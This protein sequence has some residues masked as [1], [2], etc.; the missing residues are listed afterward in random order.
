MDILHVIE[1]SFVF[2]KPTLPFQRIEMTSKVNFFI[3]L[4]VYLKKE[5]ENIF[6]ASSL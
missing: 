5:I 4:K 1:H 3:V 6:L 2:C